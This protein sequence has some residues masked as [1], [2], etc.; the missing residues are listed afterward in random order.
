MRITDK[1]LIGRP[2]HF[3]WGHC[4]Q[5]FQVQELEQ[6]PHDVWIALQHKE[7]ATHYNY[8]PCLQVKHN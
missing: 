1:E 6:L 7:E 8:W 3:P 5:Q 4:R 2:E